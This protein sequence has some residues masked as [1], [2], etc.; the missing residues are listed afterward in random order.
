MATDPAADT[1][2][3]YNLAIFQTLLAL[4]L[5]SSRRRALFQ[6]RAP[7]FQSKLC[8]CSA[9]LFLELLRGASAC[10]G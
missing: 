3:A 1:P 9:L 5:R 8:L 10:L 4:L 2:L 7:G 6:A